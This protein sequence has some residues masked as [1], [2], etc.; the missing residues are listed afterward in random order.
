MGEGARW[1]R[2]QGRPGGLWQICHLLPPLDSEQRGRRGG[3][4]GHGRPAG[5][6]AGGSGHGDGRG[7]GEKR[8]EGEGNLFPCSPRAIAHGGGGSTGRQ[9]RGGGARGRRRCGVRG[10]GE[11]ARWGCAG[12]VRRAG[13]AVGPFYRRREA[14]R[15][16]RYFSGELHSG[17]LGELREGSAGSTCAGIR[18]WMRPVVQARWSVVLCGVGRR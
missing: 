7:R 8:E 3:G 15:E 2:K 18:P 4:R 1:G 9:W 13:E 17:E 11:E 16:W 5:V 10:R 6:P 14:V 12:V